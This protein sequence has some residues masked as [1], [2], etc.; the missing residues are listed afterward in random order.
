MGVEEGWG[1]G[2]DVGCRVRVRVGRGRGASVAVVVD[3]TAGMFAVWQA[4]SINVVKTISAET[5]LIP[6]MLN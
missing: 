5:V 3:S 6:G 2:V 1:E 4:A